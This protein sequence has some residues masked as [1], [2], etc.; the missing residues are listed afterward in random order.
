MLT[1]PSLASLNF[2]LETGFRACWSGWYSAL[3]CLS[4]PATAERSFGWVFLRGCI[5]LCSKGCLCILSLFS[6][7][8]N[9]FR[10]PKPKN[11]S[12][13]WGI[14]LIF[15]RLVIS[16]KKMQ[17]S[18]DAYARYLI[19]KC[20]SGG[21]PFPNILVRIVPVLFIVSMQKTCAHV[22]WKYSVFPTCCSK[23]RRAE[24]ISGRCMGF[25]H[26]AH[27][28]LEDWQSLTSCIVWGLSA[29]KYKFVVFSIT[30]LLFLIL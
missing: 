17:V 25:I 27:L 7:N 23:S 20:C 24:I 1:H 11:A 4:L 12:L 26:L 16:A 19:A 28:S 18:L 6:S 30:L 10:S 21:L 14:L 15:W 29:I 5:L 22:H 13:E 2:F 8:L 3:L 9:L